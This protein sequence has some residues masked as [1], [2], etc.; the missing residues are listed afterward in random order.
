MHMYVSAAFYCAND[1]SQGRIDYPEPTERYSESWRDTLGNSTLD[2]V[3]TAVSTV[4]RPERMLL[5][6][7]GSNRS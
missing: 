1:Q 3:S 5:S 6:L 4:S 2:I 7:I